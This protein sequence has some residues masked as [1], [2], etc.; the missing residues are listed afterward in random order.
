MSA[1]KNNLSHVKKKLYLILFIVFL[2]IAIYS[3]FFWKTGKI[4]TK[5]EVIKPPPSVKISI[6]NGCGV[7][8]AA[9][10]VKEYFIKQDLSNIDIIAWR[11]VDRGMFIYGK[12]ILV[13]KKQDEDKLKYLIELTGITRKIYSFDPNTIED[14]QIILGSD[15]REFFN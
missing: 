6:L 4:K 13:S 9:G 5:A 7:D 8:G 14:V 15:Y 11:N 3:V 12:T 2:V 10:D 1:L